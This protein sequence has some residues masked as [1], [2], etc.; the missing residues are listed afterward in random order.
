MIAGVPLTFSIAAGIG[1]GIILY[2]AAML[3]RGR[4]REVHPLVWVLVPLF[5]VFFASDWLSANVF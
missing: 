3:A 2:V 1:F 5:L 4:G